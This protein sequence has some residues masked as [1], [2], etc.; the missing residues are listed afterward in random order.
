MIISISKSVELT[1]SGVRAIKGLNAPVRFPNI[2]RCERS[3]HCDA[4]ARSLTSAV[5]PKIL[6]Y[7]IS[8]MID[9]SI[10]GRVGLAG[11]SGN[12]RAER[13]NGD[14]ED[15]VDGRAEDPRR[16]KESRKK[17]RSPR[18]THKNVKLPLT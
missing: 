6:Y 16:R 13:R 11:P 18:L 17:K 15:G 5:K 3:S 12:A 9:P 2:G 10:T 1:L 7:G 8:E 14:E 4:L